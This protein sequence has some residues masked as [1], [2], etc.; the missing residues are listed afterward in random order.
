M[1][2]ERQR[3]AGPYALLAISERDPAADMMIRHNQ[4]VCQLFAGNCLADFQPNYE[5]DFHTKSYC[6]RK[7]LVHQGIAR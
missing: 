5:Y 3:V 4:R 7:K 1:Q 6:R 2:G